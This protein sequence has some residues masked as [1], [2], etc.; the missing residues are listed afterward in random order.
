MFA[1]LSAT[2]EAIMRAKSRD[3]AVRT[4]LR[5]RGLGGNFTSTTIVLV[6]PGS[7]FPG[8][9]SP[10]PDPIGEQ[11]RQGADRRPTLQP[12]G[13]GITRHRVPHPAAC[14]SN[15]Y[16]TD[17]A[18]PGIST[19]RSATDGTQSGAAFPLLRRTASAVGVIAVPLSSES[20]RSRPN[21]IELLQR[22]ADNVSFALGQFR[23]RRREGEDRGA[24]GAPDAHVRGAQR[25]Q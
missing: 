17:S 24:E 21:S 10:P 1:A 8:I 6:E 20:A 2:N 12:E 23:P 5:G 22:L 16:L 15:D 3:G 4:G 14:I 9:M 19:R 25:D 13:R 7:R 11:C 18:A